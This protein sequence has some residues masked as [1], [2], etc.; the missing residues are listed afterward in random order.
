MINDL[1]YLRMPEGSILRFTLSSRDS[2]R[3]ERM[4][5]IRQLQMR[6]VMVDVMFLCVFHIIAE[7]IINTKSP[8]ICPFDAP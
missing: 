8:V 3:Y 1:I 4:E 7:P 2:R 5:P 6:T